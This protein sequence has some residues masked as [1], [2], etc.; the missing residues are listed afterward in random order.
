VSGILFFASFAP[1]G[2]SP[3]EYSAIYN[4]SFLL[5]EMIIT[6]MIMVGLIRIRALQLYL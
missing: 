2:M 4:G 5:P 3:Y 1:A 6:S